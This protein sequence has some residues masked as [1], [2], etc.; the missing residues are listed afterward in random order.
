MD[1]K[2]NS[3]QEPQQQP[4]QPAKVRLPT[5]AQRLFTCLI[6][7]DKHADGGGEHKLVD[8]VKA[9]FQHHKAAPGPVIPQDFNVAQE[10]TKEERRARAEELNK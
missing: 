10:G 1:S 4:Q 9:H 3:G 7:H 5:E 2:D 8:G 6:A